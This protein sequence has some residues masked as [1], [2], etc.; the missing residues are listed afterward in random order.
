MPRALRQE[1]LCGKLI[2]NALR[3]RGIRNG[4]EIDTRSMGLTDQ[5]GA[6]RVAL[7]MA[8]ETDDV[9]GRDFETLVDFGAEFAC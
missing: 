1:R 4:L 9:L 5:Q 2:Q 7:D 3:R 8:E 6:G